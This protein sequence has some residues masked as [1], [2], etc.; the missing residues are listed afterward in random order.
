MLCTSVR[1]GAQK[2]NERGKEGRNQQ[3][4]LL[5]AAVFRQPSHQNPLG[6]LLKPHSDNTSKTLTVE[7]RHWES[8]KLPRRVQRAD[9]VETR[10]TDQDLVSYKTD[11]DSLGLEWSSGFFVTYFQV[12]PRLW[13]YRLDFE[14]Q[15]KSV[16]WMLATE[17]ELRKQP[18]TDLQNREGNTTSHA[19]S[20]TS[21]LT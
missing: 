15:R 12:I 18:Q 3:L 2:E 4:Y 1:L 10:W 5:K 16:Q 7:A 20:G 8:L 9:K 11:S 19:V 13:V 17:N 21:Y 14:E 6:K